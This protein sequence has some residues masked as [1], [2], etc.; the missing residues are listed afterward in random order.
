MALLGSALLHLTIIFWGWLQWT[1]QDPGRQIS[2]QVSLQ[3]LPKTAQAKSKNTPS[4]KHEKKDQPQQKKREQAPPELEKLLTGNGPP[5]PQLEKNQPGE[6]KETPEQNNDAEAM[7]IDTAAVPAYPDEAARQG[8]ESCVLAAIEV[9][10]AGEVS[11]VIIIHADVAKIFDQSVI[12]AQNTVHYLPA[13]RNGE[14]LPSRVLAVVGFTLEPEHHLNCAMKYAAAARAINALP[15]TT[16]IDTKI[17][18]GL[19]GKR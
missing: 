17:V 10:A 12:D 3:P 18:E 9:S 6:P 2:L 11:K 8:L 19:V 16:E 5:I 15:A 1:S 4:R 7:P 13:R 14:N